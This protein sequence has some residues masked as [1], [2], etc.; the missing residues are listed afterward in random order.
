[1][2]FCVQDTGP[3]VS[4]TRQ[5]TP[6]LPHDAWVNIARLLGKQY[7]G[8]TPMMLQTSS[9]LQKAVT[10]A[11]PDTVVVSKTPFPRGEG[12]LQ[13]LNQL[14]AWSTLTELS[15]QDCGLQ[16][17][18]GQVLAQFLNENTTLRKLDVSKNALMSAGGCAVAQALHAHRAMLELDVSRNSMGVYDAGIAAGQAFA[19]LLENNSV[20]ECLKICNN[21]MQTEA[22]S[23]LIVPLRKST[24]RPNT[25]LSSLDLS[26]N[27]LYDENACVAIKAML[28]DNS[29]LTRLHLRETRITGQGVEL[30]M[31]GMRSNTT[32]G[33]LDLRNIKLPAFTVAMHNSYRQLRTRVLATCTH[34]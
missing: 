21:Q 18:G 31:A 13:K 24:P 33:F 11:R 15:L 20:L 10:E 6:P 29:T 1:M 26:G 8:S 30:L 4:Q 32:V 19:S 27:F 2:Q 12:L 5:P 22:V 23:Q 3:A 9:K 14:S 28:E 17:A 16:E 34:S 25:T 7:P